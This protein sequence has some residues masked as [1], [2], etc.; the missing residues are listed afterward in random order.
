MTGISEKDGW[1]WRLFSGLEWLCQ[2]FRQAWRRVLA[3]WKFPMKF[4]L[5]VIWRVRFSKVQSKE[6]D[7]ILLL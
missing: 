5:T 2:R 1:F 7:L 6:N 4:L 3:R